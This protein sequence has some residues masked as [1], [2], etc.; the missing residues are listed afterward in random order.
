MFL[1]YEKA[2]LTKG[3]SLPSWFIVFEGLQ[4]NSTSKIW[5]ALNDHSY[6]HFFYRFLKKKRLN[7]F[8]AVS[9]SNSHVRATFVN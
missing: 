1:V 2:E 4:K 5:Q 8:P 6:E 3:V 9:S 7:R